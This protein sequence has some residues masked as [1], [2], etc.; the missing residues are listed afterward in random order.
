MSAVALL[1]RTLAAA[2]LQKPFR[3][4]LLDH[5]D[6]LH[7]RFFLPSFLLADFK[8]IL[9]DL[10][11]AGFDLPEDTYRAIADWRF[12]R[13]LSHEQD[14]AR[15]SI[16]KA[17]EGWPLLCETPLEGGTTS[18]F[19]DTSIERLEFL[20]N[21]TFAADC[22]IHVNGRRLDLQKFPEGKWGVG[23]RYRRTALYPSLHPGIAPQLPLWVSVTQGRKRSFYQLA[24]QERHFTPADPD[25]HLLE[26]APPCKRLHP[27]LITCDLRLP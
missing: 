2:L 20:A 17:H 6:A 3:K 23:L 1:W 18:R 26:K 8:S 7:D 10:K 5:G 25:P 11:K 16:R 9:R 14:G 22:V 27:E 19:V 4:P 15:L 24:W 13:I 12:P 21:R